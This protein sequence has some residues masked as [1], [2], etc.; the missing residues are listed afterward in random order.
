MELD[1]RNSQHRDLK[2]KIIAHCENPNEVR[3]THTALQDLGLGGITK[4]EVLAVIQE[5]IRL[6]RAIFAA[7][8]DSGEMAYVVKECNVAAAILYVKVKFF[9][10]ERKELMLLMSSHPP[11]KW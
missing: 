9:K 11:R 3:I 2:A 1:D 5:H 6:G 4:H 10:H 7:Q 8:M